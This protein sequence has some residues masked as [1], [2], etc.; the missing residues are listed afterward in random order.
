MQSKILITLNDF[1]EEVSDLESLY[2]MDNIPYCLVKNKEFEAKFS[3]CFISTFEG[4]QR[5]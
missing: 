3:A 5:E 2:F 1:T 4:N